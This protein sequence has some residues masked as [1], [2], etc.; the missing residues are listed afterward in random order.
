MPRLCTLKRFSHSVPDAIDV[1]ASALMGRGRTG[2][3]RLVKL[4]EA[5]PS[6]EAP[7]SRIPCCLSPSCISTQIFPVRARCCPF[8]LPRR[9]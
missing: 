3:V 2:F 1:V 8:R 6:P 9:G 4:R 5:Q 7:V